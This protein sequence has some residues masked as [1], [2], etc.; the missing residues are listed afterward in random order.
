MLLSRQ[1][2]DE[3]EDERPIALH[4]LLEREFDAHF[5]AIFNALVT[6]TD[7]SSQFEAEYDTIL[8]FRTAHIF[9]TS[10]G[11]MQELQS[12]HYC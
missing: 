10:S 8:V 2:N 5:F 11:E 6:E 12:T 7:L 9:I 1:L 4:G 3:A